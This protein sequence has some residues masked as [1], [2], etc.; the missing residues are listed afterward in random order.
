MIDMLFERGKKGGKATDPISE[1]YQSA[2]NTM[3]KHYE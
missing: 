1:L 2:I 3:T